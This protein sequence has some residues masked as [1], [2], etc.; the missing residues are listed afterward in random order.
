MINDTMK[1]TEI[2][3]ATAT[4]A[5]ADYVEP[6]Q[7]SNSIAYAGAAFGVVAVLAAGAIYKNFRNKKNSNEESLL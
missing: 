4:L 2:Y 7:E 5:L 6:A 1:V 3:P